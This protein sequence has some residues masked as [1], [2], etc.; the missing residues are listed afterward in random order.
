ME[1]IEEEQ[2]SRSIIE[3]GN[4]WRRRLEAMQSRDRVK[5]GTV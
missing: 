1:E 2:E 4:V 3:G 5:K